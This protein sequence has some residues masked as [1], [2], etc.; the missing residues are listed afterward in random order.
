MSRL[1]EVTYDDVINARAGNPLGLEVDVGGTAEAV[2][3]EELLVVDSVA[4]RSGAVERVVDGVGTKHRSPQERRLAL[5]LTW[6][7][8]ANDVQQL[9]HRVLA[10]QT[11]NERLAACK[12]SKVKVKHG[13]ILKPA[14]N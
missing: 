13:C 10:L 6:V 14:I 11:Q 8:R 4:V 5:R 2:W 1:R 3:E 12:M 7:C 9:F